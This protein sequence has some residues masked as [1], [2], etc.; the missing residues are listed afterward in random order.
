MA[1]RDTHVRTPSALRGDV[2]AGGALV[3]PDDG[4]AREVADRAITVVSS[5]NGSLEVPADVSDEMMPGVL[6]L[7]RGWGQDKPGT[8][9]SV[10]RGHAGVNN[11]LPAPPEFVDVPS[12]DA[13]VDGM[14]VEVALA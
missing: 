6:S 1:E 13:A 8:R 11:N 5:F 3:H 9:R 12:G 10:A 4:A 2:R 14:P 7:P